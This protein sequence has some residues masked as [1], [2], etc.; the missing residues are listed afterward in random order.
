MTF[1]QEEYVRLRLG[2]NKIHENARLVHPVF[3][4]STHDKDQSVTVYQLADRIAQIR[5][6]MNTVHVHIIEFS[7]SFVSAKQKE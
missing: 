7:V 6:D 5:Q 1:G 2:A 4:L 3:V